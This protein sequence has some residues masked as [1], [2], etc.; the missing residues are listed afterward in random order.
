VLDRD[1]QPLN[2]DIMGK[3]MS[4]ETVY[5]NGED[6]GQVS[7]PASDEVF[8]LDIGASSE[9]G[10]DQASE[11]A[12]EGGG[13]EGA[14]PTLTPF[15]ME[16]VVVVAEDS[17]CGLQFEMPSD[18]NQGKEHLFSRF[19]TGMADDDRGDT[20]TTL[21]PKTDKFELRLKLDSR[22]GDD[23]GNSTSEEKQAIVRMLADRLQS[24]PDTTVPSSG[25]GSEGYK[26][27][28]EVSDVCPEYL[29]LKLQDV[30]EL[31]PA[32]RNSTT[33][34]NIEAP[35]TSTT[36]KPV[37]TLSDVLTSEE[38][39]LPS[40]LLTPPELPQIESETDAGLAGVSPDT[41]ASTGNLSSSYY[42]D[43]K[44]YLHMAPA[45][46][47][48]TAGPPNSHQHHHLSLKSL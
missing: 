11:G 24:C 40:L 19:L 10:T 39:Q 3:T 44:G 37:L 16:A 17:G 27:S 47:S 5:D 29:A 13:G 20:K 38:H 43:N 1:Y 6:W 30:E 46:I 25:Y 41:S 2:P 9:S 33:T 28:T 7:S 12:K 32:D 45:I 4:V 8:K 15:V 26:F 48:S 35:L 42:K 14:T 22:T 34:D 18:E 21:P 36:S 23:R 31:E